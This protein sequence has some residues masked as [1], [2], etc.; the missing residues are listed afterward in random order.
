MFLK[1]FKTYL[2]KLHD[3]FSSK[4]N[5]LNHIVWSLPGR[6]SNGFILGN[7]PLI[8]NQKCYFRKLCTP[9]PA[10]TQLMLLK[11]QK[12]S[13]TKRSLTRFSVKIVTDSFQVSVCFVA[14]IL[15][16]KSSIFATEWQLANTKVIS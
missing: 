14:C 3:E 2:Q 6:K 8:E 11:F 13:L 16:R 1:V 7:I 9:L 4:I 5:L 10:S 12:R 15:L